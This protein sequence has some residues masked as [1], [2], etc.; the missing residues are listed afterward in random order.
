MSWQSGFVSDKYQT[1]KENDN[2]YCKQIFPENKKEEI[3]PDSFYGYRIFL[4]ESQYKKEILFA[5]IHY[6]KL[7]LEIFVVSSRISNW[8]YRKIKSQTITFFFGTVWSGT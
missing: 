4:K 8:G 3:F 6:S 7:L 1:P 2:V 5:W